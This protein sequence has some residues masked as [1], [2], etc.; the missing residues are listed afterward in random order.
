M[1]CP[2]CGNKHSNVIDTISYFRS[3]NLRTRR[4]KH[5][6]NEWKTKEVYITIEENKENLINS[7]NKD[8]KF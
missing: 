5:C 1:R 2:F 8:E 4:C 6:F 3:F 7:K